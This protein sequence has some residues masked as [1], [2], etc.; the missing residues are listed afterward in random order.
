MFMKICCL[1]IFLADFSNVIAAYPTND[2]EQP[3]RGDQQTI[4]GNFLPAAEQE[5][6]RQQMR[7]GEAIIKG[8]FK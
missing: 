4:M 6:V 1:L 3:M 2:R 7:G 5:Q 8:N